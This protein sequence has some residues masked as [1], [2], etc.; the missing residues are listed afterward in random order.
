LPLTHTS[1]ADTLIFSS[2]R[3]ALEARLRVERLDEVFNNRIVRAVALVAMEHMLIKLDVF[4][5]LM[6]AER[7]HG[8]WRLL[9]VGADGK[10]SP[11]GNVVIPDSVSESEIDRYLADIFHESATESHPRVRRLPS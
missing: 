5:R 1:S 3:F 6:V 11:V 9:D 10:R 2:A 7:I 4:G 8:R